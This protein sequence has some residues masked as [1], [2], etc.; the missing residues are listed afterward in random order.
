MT[1]IMTWAECF[2]IKVK[3]HYNKMIMLVLWV[4]KIKWEVLKVK[5]RTPNKI[6]VNS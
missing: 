2:V 1:Q 4:P 6:Q 5:D 3:Y